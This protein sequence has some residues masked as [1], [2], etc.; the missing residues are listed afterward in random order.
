MGKVFDFI[1]VIDFFIELF[2]WLFE[3]GVE[4]FKVFKLV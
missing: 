1:N 3:M 4:F 2:S